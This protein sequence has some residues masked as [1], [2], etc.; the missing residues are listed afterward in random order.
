MQIP[1]EQVDV[2]PPDRGPEGPSSANDIL[3]A[4]IE[5]KYQMIAQWTESLMED[6]AE[7]ERREIFLDERLSSTAD[8]LCSHLGQGYKRAEEFVEVAIALAQLPKL[9]EAYR[10]GKLSYDHLRAL[11]KVAGPDSE[12]ALIEACEG[13]SVAFAWDLVKKIQSV[14]AEDSL[15]AR[16]G[17]W[18]EMR[19]DKENRSL[20]VFGVLPEELG[21]VVKKAIDALATKMPSDPGPLDPEW[22]KK[23]PMGVRRAD[24]LCAMASSALSD[25]PARAQMVVHVEAEDLRSGEGVAEIQGGPVISVE[26]G[27]RLMC[28]GKFQV[29]VHDQDGKPVASS[30]TAKNVTKTTRM[31]VERR[32]AGKCCAPGCRRTSGLHVHHI[33]HQEH[34]GPHEIDN[35][36]LLCDI[37]H[38][39]VH[40]GGYKIRG[41]PPKISL[42]RPNR[43]PIKMGPPRLKAQVQT[44]FAEEF[45]QVMT[46]IRGP[47]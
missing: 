3:V 32:D 30:R 5:H 4:S 26:T 14:S 45:A 2:P 12:E 46:R 11:I 1:M 20:Q 41:K 34:N 27:R 40:E 15:I 35:L 23:L 25:E 13:Q 7:A 31:N 47:G 29:V 39:M 10:T 18:L 19:K 44:K 21:S 43:T 6:I 38:Y 16:S 36:V 8:W 42:E 28:D 33:V 17:R 9:K 37:H 22:M 24:A